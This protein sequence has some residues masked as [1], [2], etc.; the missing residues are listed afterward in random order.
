MFFADYIW[1]D[2]NNN[3]RS[4]VKVLE[5]ISNIPEWNYDGS[6]TN[7]A[8]CNNS[9]VILKPKKIYKCPFRRPNGYIILC[10]TWDN[11]DN[12]HTTNTRYNSDIT[13]K[14][15]FDYQAWFGI[16]QEYFICDKNNIPIGFDE[17]NKQGQYYC[18][19]GTNNAFCRNI[20]DE[21]LEYCNYSGIKMSGINAEVAPGQ[22]E[23]QIGPLEGI[24]ASDQLWV[25]RYILIRI[26]EKYDKIISFEPKLLEGNWNGSGC[27]V[28][29]STLEMRNGNGLKY[30]NKCIEMMHNNHMK[31]IKFY[32]KNNE[33]RLNENCETS[34]YN[35]FTHGVG[36]RS[37]S[38]RI[39]VQVYKDGKGYLEDRRPGANM[40]PY[41]VTRIIFS[42]VIE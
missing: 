1:I 42:N 41:L 37:A 11:E 36:D 39:P 35:K 19:V 25:S 6:S 17:N 9:E 16:E 23:Y 7:Q 2:G 18:S 3:L 20:V 30:I 40:D 29:F 13:F 26:A 14:Q 28:N 34:S 15:Y 27:H 32:G 12:P 33:K 4:K 21:H 24:N 8:S 5:N 10:D 22:W 31:D 38:V